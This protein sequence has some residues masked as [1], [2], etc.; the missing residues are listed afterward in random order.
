MLKKTI[1]ATIFA[2]IVGVGLT[3]IANAQALRPCAHPCPEPCYYSD[4]AAASVATQYPCVNAPQDAIVGTWL[5]TIAQSGA[6]FQSLATY[7]SDGTITGSSSL[8]FLSSDSGVWTATA[9]N[10]QYIAT[11]DALMFDSQ[12]NL[13]G[14]RR[15]RATIRLAADGNLIGAFVMD[16]FGLDGSVQRAAGNGTFVATRMV[17]DPPTAP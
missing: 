3:A 4:Y 8:R 13:A 2:S 6:T 9:S 7:H 14:R 15:I 5:L 17:V 11:V 16:F 1:A 10:G 12:G